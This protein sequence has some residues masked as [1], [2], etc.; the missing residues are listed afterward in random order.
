MR[1]EAA[2]ALSE[3]ADFRAAS[4]LVSLL[5]DH[6]FGVRWIAAEGLIAIGPAAL[7]PLLRELTGNSDS[8][9]LRRGAHHVMKDLI[10]KNPELENVLKNVLTG[11]ESFKP[12]I[13]VIEPA[14]AALEKLRIGV[15]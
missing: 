3:I 13:G 9:W 8:I 11:L 4:E 14:Y 2:K 7:I 10:K 15:G 1:W 6:N 5:T 12:E